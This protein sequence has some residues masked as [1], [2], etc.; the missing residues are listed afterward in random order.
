MNVIRRRVVLLQLPASC[1]RG[2]D[3]L[4]SGHLAAGRAGLGLH[5]FSVKPIDGRLIT[6]KI[7]GP[8][9]IINFPADTHQKFSNFVE[10]NDCLH[11]EVHIFTSKVTYTSQE[12]PHRSPF[13]P[14]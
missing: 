4:D 12:A 1:E 11:V 14:H 8:H 10:Y 6:G 2:G 13:C 7:H 9:A 5:Q 3:E